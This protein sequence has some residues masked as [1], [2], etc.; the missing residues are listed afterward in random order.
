MMKIAGAL[1]IGS[2]IAMASAVYMGIPYWGLDLGKGSSP[3]NPMAVESAIVTLPGFPLLAKAKG[4]TK[5]WYVPAR[6]QLVIKD[7][8]LKH[9]VCAW[10]P[11]IHEILSLYF[12]RHPAFPAVHEMRLASAK[13][14]EHLKSSI[15]K[16]TGGHWLDSLKV[17]YGKLDHLT[18]DQKTF[19]L[20]R[21]T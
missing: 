17:E 7:K 2:G 20:Q 3:E 6:I 8:K 16:M 11:K 9:K 13:T 18:T 10:T 15:L 5:E 19:C 12:N 14:E 21:Y 4:S 1:V